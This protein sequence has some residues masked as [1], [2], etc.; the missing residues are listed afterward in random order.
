MSTTR[1]SISEQ[2]DQALDEIA[3]ERARVIGWAPGAARSARLAE[4][5]ESEADWWGVLFE[6]ARVRVQWRAALTAREAAR[7]AARVWR[8]RADAEQRQEPL[9]MWPVAA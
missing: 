7:R 6:H 2:V 8:R 5:A 1:T 9:Y 3:G 4:L